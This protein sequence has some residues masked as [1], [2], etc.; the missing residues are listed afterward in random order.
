MAL[1]NPWPCCSCATRILLARNPGSVHIYPFQFYAGEKT[2]L[3]PKHKKFIL[4]TSPTNQPQIISSS[5]SS[6]DAPPPGCSRVK[7]EL[8]KPLGMILEEDSA[9]NIFVAEVSP[10][11][12]AEKSG[13]VEA[14]REEKTKT[15][16]IR[17]MESRKKNVDKEVKSLQDE[18]AKR[19]LQLQDKDK[20][21]KWLET[22][23]QAVVKTNR[24]LQ[25]IVAKQAAFRKRVSEDGNEDTECD[26][27]KCLE[28]SAEQLN[29]M[30]ER[31]ELMKDKLLERESELLQRVRSAGKR[32]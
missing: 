11:G 22:R 25:G 4:R 18:I 31:L 6:E 27:Q 12:N 30:S 19:K 21:F 8:R 7:V 20:D 16:S 24:L 32:M 14:L 1:V 26:V 17:E 10:G 5:S 3:L 29:Q 2:V 13:L 9:G 28:V 23:L 15:D